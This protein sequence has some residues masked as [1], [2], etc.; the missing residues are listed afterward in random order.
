MKAANKR[1]LLGLLFAGMMT[2]SPLVLAENVVLSYQQDPTEEDGLEAACVAL[3]LGTG[4]LMNEADVTVFATLDGVY[5]ADENTFEAE[6]DED[7]HK[8]KGYGRNKDDDDD[9]AEPMCH[10]FSPDTGLGTKPLRDVLDGFFNA[11]GNV[12]LCPL[13]YAV[14]QDGEYELIEVPY[15]DEGNPQIVIINPVPLLLGADKVIDY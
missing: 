9:D 12:L 11:G 14:R 13:C 10:T 4:M 6:D 2:A 15:D 5:I 3:Q 7:E 8:G 1:S